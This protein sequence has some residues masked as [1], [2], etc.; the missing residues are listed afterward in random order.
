MFDLPQFDSAR[1]IEVRVLVDVIEAA[2]ALIRRLQV[3]GS[4]IP[5]RSEVYAILIQAVMA[6]ARS[7]GQ[8]GPGSLAHAPLLDALLPGVE[9]NPWEAATLAV[10]VRGVAIERRV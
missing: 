5:P 8:Y 1:E 4:V 6:S 2:D 9:V 3:S 7:T 10:L